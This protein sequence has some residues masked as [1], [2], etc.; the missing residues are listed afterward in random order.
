MLL[1]FNGELQV[2]AKLVWLADL[3][4]QQTAMQKWL[5]AAHKVRKHLQPRD[6]FSTFSEVQKGHLGYLE[7]PTT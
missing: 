1:W 2:C 5:S 3:H 6:T 7:L 4:L